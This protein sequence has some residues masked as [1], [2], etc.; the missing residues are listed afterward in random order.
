MLFI[1]VFLA[2][3]VCKDKRFAVS[4]TGGTSIPEKEKKRQT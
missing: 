3:Y 2:V 1:Y 4:R